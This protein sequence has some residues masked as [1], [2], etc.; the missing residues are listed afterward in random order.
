MTPL[1]P[2]KTESIKH[3]TRG[4]ADQQQAHKE[5]EGGAPLDNS[6]DSSN[7]QPQSY[8]EVKAKNPEVKKPMTRSEWL[9][10]V[11][12]GVIA[13]ATLCY[14]AIAFYQ[15]GVISDQLKE[16]RDGSKDTKTIAEAAKKQAENTETLASAT[17]DQIKELKASV[18]AAQTMADAA[19]RG[20]KVSEDTLVLTRQSLEVSR[21]SLIASQRA[22]LIPKNM[23]VT[24][25]DNRTI[26]VK[27]TLS[28]TGRSPATAIRGILKFF[29]E[30]T[31]EIFEKLERQTIYPYILIAPGI[32]HDITFTVPFVSN[33][34]TALIKEGKIN[35]RFSGRLMY[36][37]DYADERILHLC[38]LYVAN[39]TAYR[40]CPQQYI[41][42]KTASQ[43]DK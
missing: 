43:K 2:N 8:Q 20:A 37:D 16:I 11:F 42:K 23:A 17:L 40:A 33:E 28:N 5:A 13:A 12:T 18:K 21:Q 14:A 38:S 32:D 35:G 41:E 31:P 24:V 7:A 6:Q 4:N 34:F 9:M 25:N 29:Q 36:S 3:D 27:F 15:L 30:G 22:W 39:Q 26:S 19:I 10:I 1:S